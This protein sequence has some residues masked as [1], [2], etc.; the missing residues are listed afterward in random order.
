M[1]DN[2]KM[3]QRHN[4]VTYLIFASSITIAIISLIPIV[5]PA[6]I[7]RQTSVISSTIVNPLEM[8][9]WAIPF[10][11]VNIVFFGILIAHYKKKLPDSI[12]NLI[13]FIANFEVSA[14]TAFVVVL[15]LLAVW[16]AFGASDLGK[17]E[18][19]G[20]YWSGTKQAAESFTFDGA[21]GFV[22]GFKYLLLH[23][24]L[25]IFKNIRMIPFITSFFLL[26]ITYFFTV[27]LSGKRFSGL[28]A[29][30]VLLQSNNFFTYESSATYSNFW[31]LLYLFSLYLA[32]KKWYLSWLSYLYSIFVKPL[33][34]V[35]FPLSIF[36]FFNA[37]L[38]LR[39][40]IL[41]VLSYVPLSV[42]L[43][44]I[45]VAP[46]LLTGGSDIYP[47]PLISPNSHGFWNGF[48]TFPFQLRTDGFV[49]M[50][51]IPVIVLLFMLSRK[52]MQQANSILILIAGTLFS[53][54]LLTGFTLYT[55]EP[56]R[57][58]P[59]VVFLAV[60]CGTILSKQ[61]K[62]VI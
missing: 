2:T 61:V 13:T 31:I 8:G 34:I 25:L 33:T 14:K 39:K 48:S 5:F 44:L 45:F 42:I 7:I 58:I 57:Q 20:D 23:T 55:L 62:H 32:Y 46:S 9:S 3:K 17:E 59:F 40:K 26:I 36:C 29:F 35:F 51:L 10:L 1:I 16:I 21:S 27:K 11:V 52:G 6:L 4:V 49:L 60:G 22:F 50:S 56:Y 41:L 37:D 53:S 30:I 38:A 28:I 47:L 24:S 15:I 18:Q 19:W 43:V 12:K 54:P